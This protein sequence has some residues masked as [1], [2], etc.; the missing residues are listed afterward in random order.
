[1]KI[2]IKRKTKNILVIILSCLLIFGLVFGMVRLFKNEPTTTQV[3]S[4]AYSVGALSSNGKY[5]ES[6]SSIYTKDAIGCVGLNAKINFDATVKYQIFF[7]DSKDNYLSSTK[8]L[9]TSYTGTPLLAKYCRIV[10]TPNGDSDIKFWEI[11]KYAKQVKVSVNTN[12][13]FK[14]ENNLFIA[15]SNKE[16]KEFSTSS[17]I[18][19]SEKTGVGCS[20]IINVSSLTKLY[21][22]V[23]NTL[24][25]SITI[26]YANENCVVQ[27]Q[28]TYTVTEIAETGDLYEFEIEL[29]TTARQVGIVYALNTN[30]FV[31]GE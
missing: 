3:S 25:S 24:S 2:K 15:D 10:I 9:T 8:E 26:Y 17:L 28:K 23:P 20:K 4:S 7:Y 11:S 13:K 22:L 29:P 30:V 1:M 21:V 14:Y 31:Y 12:Q 19:T 6:K 18:Q 27:S 5:K 16:N